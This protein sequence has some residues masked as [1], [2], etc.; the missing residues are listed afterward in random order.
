[1]SAAQTT[2]Q[3]I[4]IDHARSIILQSAPRPVDVLT[5]D[6]EQAVGTVCACDIAAG[7][8]L[9]SYTNSAMD[10]YAFRYDDICGL[11]RVTLKIVDHSFAGVPCQRTSFDSGTCIEI[12][13]GAAVPDAL[14]TVIPF[15]KCNIDEERATISFESASVKRAANIRYRGEQIPSGEIIVSAGTRLTSR[16]LALLAAAG[17]A[18]VRVYKPV[19]VAVITTGSELVE[20]GRPLGR[21]QTY[22]SNGVMLAAQLQ[23]LGAHVSRSAILQDC[24]DAIAQAIRLALEDND[25]VILTGGAGNGKFDL[26]QTQ[27]GS[28]GSMQP[29]F[30]N[31]RPGRPMRLG[32]IGDKPVF[33]LPGNPVAAY[34][35]FMEF[36][37]GAVIKMQGLTHK[38]WPDEQTAVLSCDVKKKAGRAEFMRGRIVGEDDGVPIVEP[39]QKQSSADLVMLAQ[40]DVIICLEHEPEQYHRGQ[41][42]RIQS[43]KEAVL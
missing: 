24:A 32:R 15:E 41:R 22:N 12:A 38:F 20:P 25:M 35:T 29:W 10:G 18:E 5:V 3:S 4:T 30:V 34:V 13:T 43:L 17:V 11:S 23:Q 33:V 27:L 6:L 26:S 7:N 40:A 16:H 37:R 28:M 2:T 42:V 19:R 36:V 8:P 21:Y 9:P 31:I 1:M 39:L 14:D